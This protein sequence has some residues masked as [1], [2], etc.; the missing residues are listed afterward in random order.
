MSD[1]IVVCP[2]CGGTAVVRPQTDPTTALPWFCPRNL[3]CLACAYSA[4]WQPEGS[5]SCWGG[6]F[7]PYFRR[8]LWLQASCCG[9]KT[10]WAFN[11]E[12][13]EL[14]DGY[15]RAR[16][17]ERGPERPYT[18][19]LEKLPAWIKSAKHRD[20]ITRTIQRLRATLPSEVGERRM[21]R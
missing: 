3:S 21:P 7:D 11:R 6:P 15:V 12:H 10:L 13:L 5:S 2:R 8:P 18:S 9:G 1:I 17:R 14:I 19:L 4:T 20:E 16:L